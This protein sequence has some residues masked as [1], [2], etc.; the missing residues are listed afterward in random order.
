MPEDGSSI[1][2]KVTQYY[3]DKVQKE[4][5]DTNPQVHV[6]DL[7]Y[8]QRLP[9]FRARRSYAADT[10]SDAAETVTAT[11]QLPPLPPVLNQGAFTWKELLELDM[12]SEDVTN[13]PSHLPSLPEGEPQGGEGTPPQGITVPPWYRVGISAAGLRT[14]MLLQKWGIPYDGEPQGGEGTPPQGITVPPWYRVGISAAGLR[15]AMLLQKWGIPYDVLEASDRPGGRIFTYKFVPDP[16][17]SP[18]G[19]HDYYDVGPM[20]YPHNEANEATFALFEELGLTPKLDKYVFS[21]PDGVMFFNGKRATVSVTG[22]PGDHFDDVQGVD[23][24]YIN[25]TATDLH[26]STVYGVDA[27]TS[28]AFDGFRKA[29]VDNPEQGWEKLMQYDWAST[30]AY[31]AREGPEFPFT[32]GYDQALSEVGYQ[33]Y[34]SHRYHYCLHLAPAP[35]QSILDSLEF[36]DP[37]QE[38]VEWKCIEGGTEVLAK[39][40]VDSLTTKP[41]CNHQVSSI[42]GPILLTPNECFPNS[43]FSTHSEWQHNIAFPFMKVD[44][45][46]TGVQIY[47]HVVSSVPFANLSMINTDDVKMTYAQRQAIRSLTYGPSV[48]V[49]IKFK[50]RWWEQNGQNLKGGSSYTDRPIRVVVYPSYG[51]GEDGPGVLIVSYTWTQDALR[52]GSLIKNPDWSQQLNPKRNHP[53]SEELMLQ[54]IYQ[55]LSTL[56]NVP[57]QQLKDDTLDYHAFNWYANPY[58]MGAFALFGPGQFSTIYKSVIQP[59][60]RGRFHFAGEA[61]SVHHAW[62]AGALDSATRVVNEILQLDF[63]EHLP[64]FQEEHGISVAFSDEQQAKKQFTKGMFAMELEEA[65]IR[66][67]ASKA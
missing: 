35:S 46:G 7:P 54:R 39:A 63:P 52:V 62:I 60:A 45:V 16:Q 22:G 57:I 5:E 66:A 2:R 12:F 65:E 31:L 41:K 64:K 47:S 50:S 61:A 44:V 4:L 24:K 67:A 18:A 56:H 10:Q 17:V 25:M 58:T 36:D 20:R 3:I 32:G 38:S 49:A 13:Q 37:S 55:D 28:I 53:P 9:H 8:L 6:G 23:Q 27:C 11:A 14:A 42:E 26:G 15:T 29:L 1:R 30:R 40:M 43:S 51:I 33:A 34:E 19:K 21:N 59:T 48:K